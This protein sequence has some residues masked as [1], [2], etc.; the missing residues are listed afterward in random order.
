MRLKTSC[1]TQSLSFLAENGH[2]YLL[3]FS[4]WP[5]SC[6]FSRFTTVLRKEASPR[7]HGAH[8][9]NYWWELI[10]QKYFKPYCIFQIQLIVRCK[11]KHLMTYVWEQCCHYYVNRKNEMQVSPLEWLGVTFFIWTF[12]H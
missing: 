5:F 6:I 2:P 3:Y 10:I 8:D 1:K 11:H 9:A 4:R 12:T 7:A